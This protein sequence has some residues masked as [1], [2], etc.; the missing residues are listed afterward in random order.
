MK[1]LL[2]MMDDPATLWGHPDIGDWQYE[3]RNGETLRSFAEWLAN[4]AELAIEAAAGGWDDVPEGSVANCVF[5][6]AAILLDLR[7]GGGPAKDWGANPEDWVGHGG[8]GLDYGC[9]SS[10]LN[11]DE[12]TGGHLP[13]EDSITE[14]GGQ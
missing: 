8:T 5:C 12:G 1:G 2:D 4:R 3:V 10:P 7:E 13:A 9:D 11:N 14:P 6:G